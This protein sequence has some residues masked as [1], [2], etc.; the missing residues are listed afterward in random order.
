MSQ[1]GYRLEF[2][3]PVPILKVMRAVVLFFCFFFFWAMPSS[4]WAGG[5]NKP[6]VVASIFPLAEFAKAVGGQDVEVKL[7]LPPGAD[8]HS[9]ELSPQDVL[10]L[11]RARLLVTVGGGLEPWL[12]DFLKGLSPKNL[13]T[14]FMVSE[15]LKHAHAN[16]DHHH[17]HGFDPHVWLDFPRDIEFVEKLAQVLGKIMPAKKEIFLQNA[18]KAKLMLQ[19][20]HEAYKNSLGACRQ[21]LVP[22]AGHMAFGYWEKNYGLDFVTLAGLSPEAEPTPKTLYQLI[23]VIE[24]NGLK[25]VYYNE[26]QNIKFAE[27][28]ARETG[29]KV[30]YLSTGAILTQEEIAQKLSFWDL[31]W[32][33][34][35]YLCLG[36]ECPLQTET[37]R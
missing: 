32:R 8:P 18:R 19:T 27:I 35:K 25:A 12:D 37:T 7:L 3:L 16:H 4:L 13:R 2:F 33:N 11:R 31:M 17:H 34:L 23:K 6:L 15:P 24:K 28:I 10:A 36:L 30:F 29:A 1:S 9:W 14:V 20:L 26:P 22:L 21:K 5:G